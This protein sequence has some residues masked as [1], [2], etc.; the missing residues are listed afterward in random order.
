MILRSETKTYKCDLVL[1]FTW[2]V[3]YVTH[4]NTYY[5]WGWSFDEF[6]VC[7]M[8]WN[9]IDNEDLL[10]NLKTQW[11][12][13]CLEEEQ[14]ESTIM[15]YVEMI[16]EDDI[17]ED[18]IVMYQAQEFCEIVYSK[19]KDYYCNDKS[20]EFKWYNEDWKYF[21]LEESTSEKA[22]NATVYEIFSNRESNLDDL[23]IDGWVIEAY[24]HAPDN[25]DIWEQAMYI[26]DCS[27]YNFK[28]QDL[29]SPIDEINLECNLEQ[30]W[31]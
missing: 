29:Q 17:S 19:L 2:Y 13:F 4:N 30:T 24:E 25:A 27:W 12:Q 18:E 1:D 5:Y 28:P 21:V 9:E 16:M 20:F 3:G 23:E 7:D 11:E 8:Q 31:K 14:N 15:K 10:N 26:A 6:Q 22:I